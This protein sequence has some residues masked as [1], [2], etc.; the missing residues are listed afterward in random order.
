MLKNINL[1]RALIIVLTAPF[2]LL[3][4]AIVVMVCIPMWIVGFF[5]GLM[6]YGFTGD[7]DLLKQL[8]RKP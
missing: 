8:F 7:P 4:G 3:V 6:E 2:W 1:V 5:V